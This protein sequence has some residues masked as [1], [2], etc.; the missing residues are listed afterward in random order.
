[1]P[2]ILSTMSLSGP[3]FLR[4]C[5]CSWK[6]FMSN[7]PLSIRIASCSAFSSSTTS[8]NCWIRPTTSP[9]PRIRLAMPSG[10]NSSRR[11]DASPI[12]TNLIGLPVTALT[13]SA[14]PPRASPSSLVRM[15]PSRL[16]RSLNALAVPTA[17]W[18]IIASTTSRMLPGCTRALI[19]DSSCISGSSMA[20]RPAVSN[21]MTSRPRSAANCT[22][23][24]QMSGGLAVRIGEHGD[25]HLL[26]EDLQLIDGGRPVHVGGDQQRALVLLLEEARQLA[27]GG[28]L[29]RALQAD[30]HDPGRALLRELDAAVDRPHQLDELV[31]A[32]L[33]EVVLG[34]DPPGLLL[35]RRLDLDD[36]A[37]RLLLHARA[38]VLHDVEADVGLEQRGAHVLQRLVDGRVIQLGEPL[39][40]LLRGAEALGQRF[41][42]WPARNLSYAGP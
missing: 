20:R 26:A 16:R 40:P 11:S 3:I 12:P 5:S 32:Q 7:F 34:R 13:D 23:R 38:E 4:T 19:C 25:V 18:P 2:G 42:H 31:V 36:D 14:A 28:R 39:E 17:S 6:S 1:M 29:A 27:D 10:R 35:R 22:A 9:R 15:T 37:D 8:S 33:H 21:R 24:S 30:Q 41:E